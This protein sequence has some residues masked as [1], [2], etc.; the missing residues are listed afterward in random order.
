MIKLTHQNKNRIKAMSFIV[1]F[2]SVKTLVLAKISYDLCTNAYSLYKNT[3]LKESLEEQTP[4]ES[5]I[6]E[7]L[8]PCL[9]QSGIRT[10]LKIKE[11]ITN[12]IC[13]AG[14][15][16]PISQNATIHTS[17]N[18]HQ[19][20]PKASFFVLK[21]EIAHIKHNDAIAILAL[22]FI[23][24]LGNLVMISTIPESRVARIITLWVTFPFLR[25]IV[26]N[27]YRYF[28]EGKADD[29]AI[30]NSSIEELQ[31]GRRFFK[32]MQQMNLEAHKKNPITASPLGENRLDLAHPSLQSRIQKIERVLKR[33]NVTIDENKEQEKIANLKG[34]MLVN[35][36]LQNLQN[37]LS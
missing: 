20:D 22:H 26:K 31:G 8:K 1:Q 17:A 28:R 34:F 24:M 12:K 9:V 33:E 11:S 18:F 5:K 7:K 2:P 10:D 14:G 32:A 23:L 37:K 25:G 19:M 30:K 15:N 4:N 29:F 27:G 36:T 35:E 13:A 21:H 6:L 3:N 16:S